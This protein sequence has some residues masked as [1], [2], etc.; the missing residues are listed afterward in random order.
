MSTQTSKTFKVVKNF[1]K[2]DENAAR[3]KV[4]EQQG[5]PLKL[6]QP[7]EHTDKCFVFTKR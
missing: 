2:G 1:V 6:L 4:S 7:G 3:Q 5:I